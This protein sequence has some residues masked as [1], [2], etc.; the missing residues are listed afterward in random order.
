M[1]TLRKAVGRFRH[2]YSLFI[3]RDPQVVTA[4]Q[5]FRDR[6]DSTLRLNY[7]LSDTSVVFDVGGYRGDWAQ[8]IASKY[9]CYVH[10]FEPVPEYYRF[11]RDRFEGRRKMVVHPFGLF[12][13]TEMQ[14]IAI[15]SDRSSL[16]DRHGKSRS[17]EIRLRDAV[18]F[19]GEYSLGRIDLIKINIEGAEYRLLKRMIDSGLVKGCTNIQVQFH[20]FYP[21]AFRLRLELSA[22]LQQTHHLTYNY[23]FV[24]EN[25]ERNE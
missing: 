1:N 14:Q 5:W 7:P 23:P 21:D 3:L 19:V 12:D 25:W 9:D 17:V 8:A 20:N 11:I 2:Y 10:I 4:R 15:N 24:W 6:G 16:Y 22:R 13:C 18:E